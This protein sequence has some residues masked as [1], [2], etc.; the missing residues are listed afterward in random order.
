MKTVNAT[1]LTLIHSHLPACLCVADTIATND[2]IAV[3]LAS[4]P[5]LGDMSDVDAIEAFL[6]SERNHSTSLRTRSTAGAGSPRGYRSPRSFII[7]HPDSHSSPMPAFAPTMLPSVPSAV[8][9][10]KPSA[11]AAVT[12]ANRPPPSGPLVARSPASRVSLPPLLLPTSP[13]SPPLTAPQY[14]ANGSILPAGSVAVGVASNVGSEA[15]TL[16]GSSAAYGTAAGALLQT[17]AGKVVGSALKKKGGNV[18]LRRAVHKLV[19]ISRFNNSSA[20]AA[21]G[22]GASRSSASGFGRSGWGGFRKHKRLGR[23]VDAYIREQSNLYQYGEQRMVEHDEKL[24]WWL[25]IPD[26]P[27][28]LLWDVLTLMLV[29]Y[30]AITTPIKIGFDTESSKYTVNLQS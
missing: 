28:R 22:S 14:A 25:M 21:G 12:G 7:K 23:T 9:I 15:G 5:Y 17:S 18:K 4:R 1:H 19:L 29:L 3:L 13:N 6:H 24:P 30:S 20:P 11:G 16:V 2:K 10:Q 8:S 27:L 26:A